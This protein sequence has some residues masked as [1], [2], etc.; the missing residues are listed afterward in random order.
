[1]R[2]IR[3][4][5]NQGGTAFVPGLE[6]NGVAQSFVNLGPVVGTVNTVNVFEFLFYRT[7]TSTWEVY[8][9]Q[10]D[11]NSL[12]LDAVTGFGA[13]TTNVLTTGGLDAGSGTITTTG[14]VN[15]GDA[16]VG[17]IQVG[18]TDDNEI[19]T[20]TGN[21]T[22]DSAGGTVTVADNL[23]VTGNTT[24]QGNTIIGNAVTDTITI[25]TVTGT[26]L[27]TGTVSGY[28]E[29]TINGTTRYVPYYT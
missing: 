2:I 27:N 10:I 29:I 17:N 25:Q 8:C 19:D 13:T 9:K 12:T 23:T 20:T 3:I 1:M 6:I 14:A 4:F 24:L 16:T 11:A 28:M 18:V 15:G 5:I 26:P 22:I 21:L 7:H